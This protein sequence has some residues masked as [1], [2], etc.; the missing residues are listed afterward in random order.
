MGAAML[1]VVFCISTQALE[2]EGLHQNHMIYSKTGT[3]EMF[4]VFCKLL[5]ERYN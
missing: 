1:E 3:T 2:E 4:Y 5:D